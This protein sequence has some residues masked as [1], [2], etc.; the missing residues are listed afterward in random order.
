MHSVLDNFHPAVRT[1]FGDRFGEPSPAQI[2][3]WPVIAAC[4][5]PPGHDVLL[6]APTGSGK[7]LAAFMWA[8]DR[9]FRDAER[10]E[11]SDRIRVLYV[12]PLKALANDIRVNLEEP[13]VGIRQAAAGLCEG[14]IETQQI[15]EVRAGLRTGDTPANE[16]SAMLRRPPHILVTTPESLF[17]L[18]TSPRFRQNLSAVRY[19]IVDELHA[20]AP[21]KRGAHLMITLERLERM[22]RLGGAPRPVRIGLSATLH[23]IERLAAFLSGA[24]ESADG[25]RHTRPVRI[26]R[27]DDRA[28]WLDLAVI[29][30]GP[31]VGALATHQHWEAMYDAVAALVKEHRTTLVFTLSR[32][33]AERIALNLQ[34]R[35][36]A[37]AVMAHHGSLARA[38]RLDAEQRLKRG[39]LRAIVATASLE[40]GIDVGAVEL[41]CQIDSPKT[42]SAAIQ[43]IG[44]S[45]HRLDATPR[46]RL[47]ALTIDD[48]LECAAAVRAIRAGR[49]DEV[50]IPVGC[51][52]VAAQQIVAI[53]AEESEIGE[54]ELLRIL[55]GAYN[56][57]DLDGE[58]LARLLGQMA[59]ELSTRVQ[60]AAPKIFYDRTGGR[61]R[62]RRGARLAA[63]T[64]GGTIPE[65]GN[66]DVVI[67]SQGRKIGDVEED[68]AQESSRGDIFALG[69]M[70]WRVLG[71]SR[72]RF[73]VE[74]APGMA[75]S[76]PFW[77]TEA[78]GRSPALSAEVSD[79]RREV[80][81]RAASGGEDGAGAWLAAE[82]AIDER[83]ARQVVQYVRRGEAALEALPDQRTLIVERFFDGLGG[84][85]VV[86]HSPLGIRVN[87]GLGLA[88]RKRL[89]QSF[90]FEIQ[91]SAIDDAVLLALNARHSFPLETLT[92]MLSAR[93]LRHV[94]EQ[95]LLAAPMFEVRLRHVA[96]RALAV[97][98]SM[99][100]R[101]VPAW[102][103][104][105]RTQEVAAA[106]FPQREACLENRPAEVALPDHFI[107]GETMRECLEE[108]TDIRRLLDLWRG[109]ESGEVRVVNVDA[110]APSVFAHRVL[111]AWDYSFLDDGE[112]ANRRSRTVMLNRSMAEDVL[113][114]EDLSE[115]LATEAVET[116]EAEVTGR[117]VSRRARDRDELYELIRS[118]GSLRPDALEE[119]VGGDWR[120]ILAALEQEGRVVRLG[121]EP[122]EAQTL[123]AA[124]D[125]ALF[126][127]A[128]PGASVGSLAAAA[129]A[130]A[131]PEAEEAQREIVRRAL[132][133]SG[134]VEVAELGERLRMLPEALERH[135]T[136]LEAGG[137]VFRGHFTP[138]RFA[139]GAIANPR[140]ADSP[141]QWCDR[142]NLERI[143]RLTLNRLRSEVEPC[144][145]D[146]Y[147]AFRMR[148]NHIGGAGTTGD[149]SGVA[150]VLEQLS[151]LAF[152][153]ELWERAILPARIPGYLPEW[154]DLL[155]LGGEVVWSAVPGEAAV[156]QVPAR[157]TFFRRRR[158]S[159]VSPDRRAETQAEE[160]EDRDG[161]A[162]FLA[163]AAGGAQYLDELADRAGLAERVVLAALWRLAAAGKVSND[164]FAPLRLLWSAPRAV[165]AIAPDRDRRNRGDAALRARLRS[166]VAGRWSTLAS[167]P[168][169]GG[170]EARDLARE[171]ALALLERN[172]ILTR[173]ML[174]LESEPVP[175]QEISFALRRMEYAGTVRRGYFVRSLSGEQYATPP[176]LEMLA[177][178]RNLNPARERL[179]ALSA[180]DPANPH[181]AILPGCGVPRDASNF[182]V[183]RAGRAVLGLAG[184]SL[185]RID[186]LDDEAFS[187]GLAALIELKRKV[188]VETID[189]AP[190]L[191]S[192]W[193]GTMAAMGFHSDGRAL[194]YDG[195]PGPAPSRAGARR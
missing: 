144:S 77:Q 147:A 155:C 50:E 133:T 53:A 5:T 125:V 142:Y 69:S 154:L 105:L 178:A 140:T 100:G 17:I 161:R 122:G 58:G 181:G 2:K 26:V 136:A 88:L 75:P 33:W 96:T 185:L 98:R 93:S 14:G 127:A 174:A 128:Y 52:D 44:R 83:A 37:D 152:S 45:G 143:H 15:L 188:V 130:T 91:A 180:V 86:I 177:A 176:A 158:A 118:H 171:R 62:A 167:A 27:A 145:D 19:V 71:I 24:N 186:E 115:M 78:A 41:V 148:W 60:G 132:R 162:V 7:T 3:G 85:Q 63:I 193:V 99:R 30:P 191:N 67:A 56:F 38:E 172:G 139:P 46:G 149:S 20:L 195:L 74:P 104:R 114:T 8:I 165:R 101:K 12:S 160:T 28:R 183:F 10:G 103:Q 169:A 108:S 82:C 153:P 76:L 64:S 107:V 164:S 57:A 25:V 21:N 80:V 97:M 150:I 166:S 34:K 184:R 92:A 73:M 95:A 23:P 42:I 129:L 49:L 84:T 121:L 124:E 22:A 182:I 138:R 66:L 175:W 39:D 192:A 109:I 36:G 29:A 170:G 119:R 90:D 4:G 156:A 32:R 116:V 159:A 179:S 11:L 6:C 51:M 106:I 189:G 134:P 40:L 120:A 94:L 55:R 18:L 187:A 173:E 157:I 123:I 35:L 81:T 112:R 61:V 79:L 131:A 190:A 141:L 146:V 54:A 151:G 168:A 194:V 135:L 89:C 9:L 16:R 31:E 102:I 87:R 113:R 47:F 48:L 13:L 70:P 117:A 72:N 163:L 1:W 137:L 126:A 110:V 65:S 43:R 68:F 59:A 111:L